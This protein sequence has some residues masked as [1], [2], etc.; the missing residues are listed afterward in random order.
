MNADKLQKSL[1]QK[2]LN[3]FSKKDTLPLWSSFLIQFITNLQIT[4]FIFQP[5]LN[6]V[7]D[8]H[9][10]VFKLIQ[11][12]SSYTV[13]MDLYNPLTSVRLITSIWYI[14][15]IYLIALCL[16][17]TYLILIC[18]KKMEANLTALKV[19]V[20]VSVVQSKL[21]F[22]PIHYFLIWI[23]FIRSKCLSYS[24]NGS[25][26]CGNPYLAIS[27][28]LLILNFGMTFLKEVFVYQ[29]IKT[30][31]NLSRKNNHYFLLMLLHKTV[32]VIILV[33]V[34]DA[35]V[36]VFVVNLIFS[37]CYC[38]TLLTSLP[39]Y[40]M[41]ILKMTTVFAV[42][43]STF[44]IFIFL[45]LTKSSR[46][47][48]EILMAIVAIFFIRVALRHME[49]TLQRILRLK[50]GNPSEA[51]H[52]L[53]LLKQCIKDCLTICKL[54]DRYLE[55]SIRLYGVLKLYNIEIEN[56]DDLSDISEHYSRLY[57]AILSRLHEILKRFP[58]S[59][60]VSLLICKIYLKELGHKGKAL[61]V[62]NKLEASKPSFQGAIAVCNIY[63]ELDR[64]YKD[65][66]SG[67]NLELVKYFDH[68]DDTDKI[69]ES[70]QKEISLHIKIW[71]GLGQDKVNVGTISD[72]SL[73]VDNVYEKTQELWQR[74]HKELNKNFTAHLLMYGLYLEVVR[75][76]SYESINILKKF[77][78]MRRDKRDHQSRSKDLFSE[79]V[80]IILASI[81]NDKTGII[82]DTSASVVNI[83]AIKKDKLIGESVNNVLPRFIAK[84]HDS[85]IRR[86]NDQSTHGLNRNIE[87]YG[88]SRKGHYFPVKIMLRIYPYINKGLNVLAHVKRLRKGDQILILDSKG[89]IVDCSEGLFDI[90]NL[91]H[92]DL[93]KID[94]FAL[95]P[96]LEEIDEAFNMVYNSEKDTQN[97]LINRLHTTSHNNAEGSKSKTGLHKNV[98]S[99]QRDHVQIHTRTEIKDDL[100]PNHSPENNRLQNIQ[101]FDNENNISSLHPFSHAILKH[102]SFSNFSLQN[103]RVMTPIIA[104][105]IC[106]KYQEGS[107]LHFLPKKLSKTPSHKED[108]IQLKVT[109]RPYI[110]DSDLYKIIKFKDAYVDG[111]NQKPFLEAM[112][113]MIQK[114]P[115]RSEGKKEEG[116]FAERFSTLNERSFSLKRLPI[117]PKRMIADQQAKNQIKIEKLQ[118]MF[119]QDADNETASETL[120][121]NNPIQIFQE[122]QKQ[123]GTGENSSMPSSSH[124]LRTVKVLN[125]LFNKKNMRPIT[126]I[127]IALVYFIMLLM[128]LLVIITFIFTQKTFSDVRFGTTIVDTASDR[129]QYIVNIWEYTS[130]LYSRAVRLRS[131][132]TASLQVFQ[133]MLYSNT[134]SLLQ[135]NSDLQNILEVSENSQLIK[136]FFTPNIALWIPNKNVTFDSSLTNTFTAAKVICQKSMLMA[137][138]DQPVTQLV[139]QEDILFLLNNT[140]NDLLIQSRKQVKAVEQQMIST[141]NTNQ[142]FEMALFILQIFSLVFVQIALVLVVRILVL[143]Y[144]KLFRVL[145]RINPEH[146]D[147][148]LQ[149]LLL[150]RECFM[151]DIETREFTL[152]AEAYLERGNNHAKKGAKSKAH[153]RYKEDR[154]VF[155][156]IIIQGLRP[157]IF[158]LVLIIIIL[159][160]FYLN[161]NWSTSTFDTLHQDDQ[162]LSL[163]HQLSY[164][165][166]M[167]FAIFY[168][169]VVFQ[170][171]TGYTISS[172][173]PSAAFDQTLNFLSGADEKLLSLLSDPK[174]G[175]IDPFIE[176]YTKGGGLQF[177]IFDEH[178]CLLIWNFWNIWFTWYKYKDISVNVH[179]L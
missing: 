128:F 37:L 167:I 160:I 165:Y 8:I 54:K 76:N 83:F 110:F 43:H 145:T 133:E 168:T 20:Q 118:R 50:F 42:C 116:N 151:K 93:D 92:R 107:K 1:F 125:E 49:K 33:F 5:S 129:L 102:G 6:P 63:S 61:S 134:N 41:L 112:S 156:K 137:E 12:V 146:Q 77:Y 67:T 94:A 46:R 117:L 51:A 179:V 18:H 144:S 175:I 139:G 81:E 143:S 86:Y 138:Y 58:D 150:M 38:Y 85:I 35:K 78:D 4:Y 14:I 87:A 15:L 103:P 22:C 161:Y 122:F 2:I 3:E 57:N 96:E 149:E 121:R 155:S 36:G 9:L 13:G 147:Q 97:P 141:I 124:G 71:K 72:Y 135:A 153:V 21:L 11:I 56:P 74:S 109:I 169:N 170:N 52:I 142:T 34:S 119:V 114:S 19:T 171:Q 98:D 164:T 48:C 39:F 120:S 106:Q 7:N 159:V 60:I 108:G 100:V 45:S 101:L 162:K 177:I 88:K 140:S 62:L 10:R 154:L 68:R 152:K 84:K 65:D 26:E 80:A 55:G 157:L 75:K 172:M 126:K 173:S 16:L 166:N 53:V 29:I 113:P 127:A 47:Y 44:S 105:E 176:V 131:S 23:I 64:F 104:K 115:V 90:F 24:D 32:I 99:L 27:I 111:E 30:K 132:T 25:I 31:N 178:V 70:I 136:T 66:C 28:I 59:E 130:I 17:I 69:K 95:C 158:S 82:I 91:S 40:N 79:E 73:E 174:Q 123:I 163:I 148:R 89:V